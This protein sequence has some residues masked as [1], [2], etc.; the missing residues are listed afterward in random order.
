MKKTKLRNSLTVRLTDSDHD[1]FIKLTGKNYSTTLR[2]LIKDYINDD[3][4]H[5]TTPGEAPIENRRLIE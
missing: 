2:Q 3:A 4:I 5:N 1:K